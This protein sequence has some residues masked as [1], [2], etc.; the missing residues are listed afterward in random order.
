MIASI[1]SGLGGS[2]LTVTRRAAGSYSAGVFVAGSTSTLTVTALVAPVTG[3]DLQR[4][5]PGRSSSDA[6]A[7]L[8]ATAVLVPRDVAGNGQGGDLVSIGG[9]S[10]EVE[11]VEH[12]SGA[13]MSGYRAVA[14]KVG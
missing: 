12:F 3:E 2:A 4:L 13:G 14:L 1:V 9:V 7:L 10:Y 5:P 8:T 11:R 6:R